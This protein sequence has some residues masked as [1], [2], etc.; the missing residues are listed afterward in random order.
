[1]IRKVDMYQCVCDRCGKSFFRDL[2][3]P[4]LRQ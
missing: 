1:M 4:K 2:A 3:I